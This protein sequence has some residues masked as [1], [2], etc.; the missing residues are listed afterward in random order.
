MNKIHE[1]IGLYNESDIHKFW[2]DVEDYLRW[3]IVYSGPGI[4][5]MY[6][7]VNSE[8]GDP[9]NQWNPEKPDAWFIKWAS[10]H[11][12]IT[13]MISMCMPR[14]PKLIFYRHKNGED[15]EMKTYD[16][17]KFAG[18]WGVPWE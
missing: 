6:K 17:K 4:F 8:I 18:K 11:G 10:G 12:C 2:V 14:L 16:F 15:S 3:G 7:M 13:H 9:I 1:I 5:M